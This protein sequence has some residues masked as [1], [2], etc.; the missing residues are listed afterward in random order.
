M[1]LSEL[2]V[3]TGATCNPDDGEIEIAGAAGLDQARSG[4][5]TF[6]SNPRYTSRVN[7][8]S[9]SAIYVAEDFELARKDLAL[10]RAK[11]PYLAFTRAL[12]AFQPK[13]KF[14]LLLDPSAVVD[15]ST[16]L[17]KEIFI[18]A[19]VAIGKNCE[20]GK[21]VRVHPNATIYDNVTI[22]DDTEIH[23]GVAIRD[24]SVIGQRVIIR[25]S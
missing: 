8:T 7:D 19:H 16:R 3:L 4:Q 24:G 11:D 15:S 22:G 13:R 9:A 17:P 1:K 25:C 5:I 10:L 14:E 20:I 2:A 18:D 23:S 21:R 6:L 12:I